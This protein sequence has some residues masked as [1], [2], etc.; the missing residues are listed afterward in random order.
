VVCAL[1][2]YTITQEIQELR[3]A[4]DSSN[5]GENHLA[6]ERAM[7]E[8]KEAIASVDVEFEAINTALT[9]VLESVKALTNAD[10]AQMNEHEPLLRKHAVLLSEWK[11]I[12]QEVS[13]L[14]NELQEDQLLVRFRTAVDQ[15]SL[16]NLSFGRKLIWM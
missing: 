3:H 16:F 15:V 2:L 4:D 9:P 5:S 14:H 10:T 6:I 8:L 11:A 1:C 13:R 12:H 7:S